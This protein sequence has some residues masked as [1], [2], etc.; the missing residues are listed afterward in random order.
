M[1]GPL[2]GREQRLLSYVN[3][4]AVADAVRRDGQD[5]AI[6]CAGRKGG[7]AL[8]DA[9]CAGALV[10]RLADLD[11][12]VQLN[13]AAEM[14]RAYDRAHGH[15]PDAILRLSAHGRYLVELGLGEDLAVCG[16]RS[17]AGGA[18]PQGREDRGAVPVAPPGSAEAERRDHVVQSVPRYGIIR[19]GFTS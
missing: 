9:A 4:S 16:D 10:R 14:A 2:N 6:L 12:A 8:D 13:D 11:L 17:G 15:D 7:F 18:V 1:A 3:L 19:N 5:V